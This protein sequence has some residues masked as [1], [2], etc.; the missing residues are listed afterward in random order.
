MKIFKFIK[1]Y[2][3][4]IVDYIIVCTL[5]GLA[6]LFVY[7]F[8]TGYFNPMIEAIRDFAMTIFSYNPPL[9]VFGFG[10][11]ISAIISIIDFIDLYRHSDHAKKN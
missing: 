5:I 7:L 4:D 3:K 9:V 11:V 6:C 10:F 2:F 8:A 1:D